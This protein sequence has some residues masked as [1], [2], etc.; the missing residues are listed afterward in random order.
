MKRFIASGLGNGLT[1]M[2]AASS[3][4]GVVIVYFLTTEYVIE[5]VPF[6][7]ALA[8]VSLLDFQLAF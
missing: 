7:L 2:M 6:G 3:E 1:R 5:C 8:F 4:A